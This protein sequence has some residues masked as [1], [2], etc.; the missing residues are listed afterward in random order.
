M[1]E[2]VK[3]VFRR[4]TNDKV[5]LPITFKVIRFYS[6]RTLKCY[7]FFRRFHYKGESTCREKSLH[8]SQLSKLLDVH[9]QEYQTVQCVYI[10][11][12]IVVSVV[13]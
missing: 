4:L 7:D 1:N 9:V 12:N 2:K 5:F 10:K 8:L 3:N 13:G 11:K 6:V